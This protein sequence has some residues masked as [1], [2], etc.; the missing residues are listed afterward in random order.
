MANHYNPSIKRVIDL[1]VS[2]P[3]I[4]L[5]LPLMILIWIAIKATS[6]GPALFCQPRIGKDGQ[7]FILL[8]F[9]SMSVTETNTTSF[10]KSQNDPRVTTVGAVLRQTSLDELP[11]LFNVFMGDMSLVGPRP[12]LKIMCNDNDPRTIRRHT[13]PPG[14]T[15]YWQIYARH[16]NTSIELMFPYDL[17]YIEE[18][19]VT[20]D[21]KILLRTIP[22]VFSGSGAW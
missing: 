12:L 8:K 21:L 3:L 10:M 4:L 1:L 11:Q 19:S 16:L 22:A 17:R 20:V 15:G 13:V 9:R 2:I 18:A 5:A 14:I 6:H 7:Q